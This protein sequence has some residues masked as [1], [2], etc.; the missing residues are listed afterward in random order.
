MSSSI[1]S[2]VRSEEVNPLDSIRPKPAKAGLSVNASQSPM[3]GLIAEAIERSG[4]KKAAAGD[5]EID[6]AQLNRQLQNGHLTV[7]RLESLPAAFAAEFGRLLVEE[8]A[9]LATP[10][11]RIRELSRRQREIADELAQL[12]EYVA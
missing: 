10:K 4:T 3:R 5:M 1:N 12:S 2:A 8:F 11:A 6:P 9:P 7:E